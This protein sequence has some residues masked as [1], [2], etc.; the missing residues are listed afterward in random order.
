VVK[1]AGGG[2]RYD[3]ST[4]RYSC[5]VPLEAYAHKFDGLFD[6]LNQRNGFR[7]YLAG[8]LL[9]T[10]RHKSLTG[11]AN[12]EPVV[13]AQHRRAQ[14]LQWFLSES[15]WSDRALQPGVFNFCSRIR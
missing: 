10:E 8:L 11:L 13:G 4:P 3:G 1:G 9:P 2:K 7:R 6:K 5:P 15:M 14:A 12:T